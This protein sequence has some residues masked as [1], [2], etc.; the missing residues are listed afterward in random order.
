VNTKRVQKNSYLNLPLALPI[1]GKRLHMDRDDRDDKTV[2]SSTADDGVD[3]FPDLP[4]RDADAAVDAA[5]DAA[6]GADDVDDEESPV[7]ENRKKKKGPS[8]VRRLKV[9]ATQDF[10]ARLER[11]GIVYLSR[12][13]PR[14]GPA[15]VKTLLSDFGEVTRIY[16]VEEDKS[17]RKRRRKAGGSGSK[18]YHE[19]WVEFDSKK[20]AKRVGETLNATRVTNHKGSV[21]YDDMWNIKYLRG[22]KWSH[23]TEKVAYERRVREQKL[24][25]E[26]MEVRRENASYVGKVEAGRRLDHIEERRR[27]RMESGGVDGSGGRIAADDEDGGV[28]KGGRKVRQKKPLEGDGRAT[29][30]AIL[31]SL[32]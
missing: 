19:G 1:M 7:S 31:G 2:I 6:A 30:S 14:M 12:V 27:R 5:V 3:C 24:R 13:P 17:S 29:K 28:A 15:K 26:M 23:L 9:S 8:A 20:V 16:L 21:N 22:F 32:V 4:P 10:N 18:R 25:V 11:R